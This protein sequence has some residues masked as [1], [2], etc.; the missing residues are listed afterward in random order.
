M[1]DFYGLHDRLKHQNKPHGTALSPNATVVIVDMQ[2]YFPACDRTANGVVRL[3]EQARKQGWAVVLL[4]HAGWSIT[5]FRLLQELGKFDAEHLK[6]CALRTKRIWDG[7]EQVANACAE[8]GL[9]TER[10]L[11]G[12]VNTHECVQDTVVGLENRLPQC[13]I[14]VVAEACG[15]ETPYGWSQFHKSKRVGVV[16]TADAKFLAPLFRS[17]HEYSKVS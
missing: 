13:R 15:C 9:P 11:F 3:L 12:G 2:V 7:S 16:P 1:Y 5:D 17:S 10:F 14:D 6:L 8:L 4:E